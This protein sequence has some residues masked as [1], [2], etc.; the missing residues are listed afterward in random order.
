MDGAEES[1]HVLAWHRRARAAKG[2]HEAARAGDLAAIER[3]LDEGA[4]IEAC[5]DGDG[6]MNTLDWACVR[7]QAEAARRLLDLGGDP[8]W[9]SEKDFE[10]ATASAGSCRWPSFDEVREG[11]RTRSVYSRSRSRWTRRTDSRSLVAR[12]WALAPRT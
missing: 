12:A 8:D 3:Q 5:D 7:G 11:V 4:D 10:E 6:G 2:L 9:H 1:P